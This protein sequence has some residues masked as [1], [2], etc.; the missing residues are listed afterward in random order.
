MDNKV[1]IKLKSG[2]SNILLLLTL[3]VVFGTIYL[4]EYSIMIL[5][6]YYVSVFL[7][8]IV[9][10]MLSPDI[11]FYKEDFKVTYPFNIRMLKEYQYNE[12]SMVHYHSSSAR[13][14]DYIRLFILSNNLTIFFNS[15]DNDVIGILKFLKDKNINLGI[16][17]RRGY[18]KVYS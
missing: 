13:G 12:L 4:L 11:I 16:D 3:F 9:H 1:N 5:V 10:L 6:L 2:R 8:L 18:D 15:N 14:G 17:S 7:L